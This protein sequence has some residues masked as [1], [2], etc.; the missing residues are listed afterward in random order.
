MQWNRAF[1]ESLGA[2]DLVMPLALDYDLAPPSPND[3]S[4]PPL[5]DRTVNESCDDV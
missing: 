1:E 2:H 4:L 3:Y 5:D